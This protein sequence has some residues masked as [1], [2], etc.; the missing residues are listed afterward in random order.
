NTPLTPP[1][2]PVA[3]VYNAPVYNAPWDGGGFYFGPTGSLS[4]LRD[5]DIIKRIEP[6]T[7]D[8]LISMPRSITGTSTSWQLSSGSRETSNWVSSSTPWLRSSDS[9]RLNGEGS[10]KTRA[11]TS[12]LGYD[13]GARAGYQFGNFRG[14]FEFDYANNSVDTFGSD[15]R[16]RMPTPEFRRE[17]EIS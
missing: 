13:V 5:S 17:R 6:R 15:R 4:V 14:E 2:Q 10:S 9:L 11:L 1:P 3:V 16:F 7:T 8:S 12:S